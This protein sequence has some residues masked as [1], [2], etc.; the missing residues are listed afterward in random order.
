M[1]KEG[2]ECFCVWD[3]EEVQET[4]RGGG[5]TILNILLLKKKRERKD[6][7]KLLVFFR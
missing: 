1:Q 5:C 6:A 4:D 2:Q 3:D 7:L